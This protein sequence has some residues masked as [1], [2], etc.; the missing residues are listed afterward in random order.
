MSENR[1]GDFFDSH[2]RPQLGS[3]SYFHPALCFDPVI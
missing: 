3:P 2:C 1:G